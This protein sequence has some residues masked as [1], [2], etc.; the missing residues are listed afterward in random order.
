MHLPSRKRFLLALTIVTFRDYI[1]LDLLIMV[2][3]RKE[4]KI[5]RDKPP[6][7]II[8]SLER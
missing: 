4:R 1:K 3:K 8:E 5:D 6:P 7:D 2:R